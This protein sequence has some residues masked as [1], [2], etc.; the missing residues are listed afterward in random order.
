MKD[1]YQL[2]RNINTYATV[3]EYIDFIKIYL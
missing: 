1:K 3:A 2:T